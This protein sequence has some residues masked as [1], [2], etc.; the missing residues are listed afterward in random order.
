VDD[1]PGTGPTW[2]G[3]YKRDHEFFEAP[4]GY[5]LKAGDS[6]AKW[7][8]YLRESILDPQAKVVLGFPKGGMQSYADQF[9]GSPDKERRLTAIVEYIKSLDNHAPGGKPKYYHPLPPPD[10][11]A[12]PGEPPAAKKPSAEDKPQKQE[13]QK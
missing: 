9:S 4:P 7:D 8:A 13:K 1:S 10:F 2:L 3:L 12:K 5:T 6:D 11:G